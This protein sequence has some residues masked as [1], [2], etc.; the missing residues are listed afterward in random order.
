M[1]PDRLPTALALLGRDD[2]E[3]L[4]R[5]LAWRAGRNRLRGRTSVAAWCEALGALL[6]AEQAARSGHACEAMASLRCLR[7]ATADL[8]GRDRFLLCLEY[9]SQLSDPEGHA[10][11]PTLHLLAAIADELRRAVR[12]GP[13]ASASDPIQ[14]I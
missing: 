14:S 13:V 7:R 8:P 12:S 3:R 4:T 10:L 9:E 2:L 5:S 11:R 1:E 6:D